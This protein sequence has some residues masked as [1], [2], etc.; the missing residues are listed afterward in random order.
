M[1]QA[2]VTIAIIAVLAVAVAVA[3]VSAKGAQKKFKGRVIYVT[4][5]FVELKKSKNEVT[6]YFT[7][8]SKVVGIDGK[9]SDKKAL[10]P[11]QTAEALY[12][13]AGGKRTIDVITIVKESDCKR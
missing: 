8:A 3:G 4:D 1:K 9:P 7:D 11:C 5:T 6:L 2:G 13:T 10:E 12:T